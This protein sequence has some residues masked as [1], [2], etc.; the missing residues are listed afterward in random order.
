MSPET[1]ELIRSILNER[2]RNDL[3][4]AHKP[5]KLSRVP[6]TQR[7]I[8]AVCRKNAEAWGFIYKKAEYV[9]S[10][11]GAFGRLGGGRRGQQHP[12]R[13]IKKA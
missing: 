7:E 9:P 4:G 12:P 8:V 1:A 11:A 13:M 6:A 5:P 10:G 2:E 3:S